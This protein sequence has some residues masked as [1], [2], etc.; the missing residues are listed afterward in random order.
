M[1]DKR[2]MSANSIHLKPE[3]LI[4]EDHEE[5]WKLVKR[6]WEVKAKLPVASVL[7]EQLD[8]RNSRGN[9]DA[10]IDILVDIRKALTLLDVEEVMS[11]F[12][13]FIKEKAFVQLLE[14]NAEEFQKRSKEKAI[15][16]LAS[17]SKDIHELT[18]FSEKEEKV[19]EDFEE[20]QIERENGTQTGTL[21]QTNWAL[22]DRV[23][24]GGHWT[25][26]LESWLGD[27]GSGKSK[28][29]VSRGIQTA[30]NGHDVLHVQLE[31]TKAQAM[32]NYDAAWS[33]LSYAD[34]RYRRFESKEIK[35]KITKLKKASRKWLIM[36][37]GEV[38][39]K[40]VETFGGMS[41]EELHAIVRESV[42]KNPKIKHIIVDYAE[43]LMIRGFVGSEHE[44]LIRVL[45]DLKNIA[46]EF[47]VLVTTALQSSDINTADKNDPKFV[48]TRHNIG[49]SKRLIE[50]LSYLYTINQTRDE[51]EESIARIFV[52]KLRES[53]SGQIIKIKQ[54]LWRSEFYAKVESLQLQSEIVSA[55][56]VAKAEDTAVLTPTEEIQSYDE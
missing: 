52:D 33:R 27:S 38:I 34:F 37:R 3:F 19:F 45:R 56:D 39:I 30:M 46:I 40:A 10:Q 26:E 16:N 53:R 23:N 28:C 55:E 18:I 12:E 1:V 31:G 51:A 2:A 32:T 35:D 14:E 20:R 15:A 6:H 41:S 13:S 5:I 44:R 4:S 17:G 21:L 54:H 24:G 29:L 8:K 49:K 48:M 36:G 22:F 43:L 47:D 25:G 11:E 9:L 42:R 50:P 7:I